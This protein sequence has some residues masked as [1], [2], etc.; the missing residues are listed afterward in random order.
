MIVLEKGKLKT[1]LQSIDDA[2]AEGG[3]VY[4]TCLDFS[5]LTTSIDKKILDCKDHLLQISN[6][7][8][9]LTNLTSSLEGL[10][11]A[12]MDQILRLEKERDNIIRRDT[13]LSNFIDP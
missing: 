6:S 8:N 4:K 13:K 12:V 1:F 7:Y 11:L 10:I 3:K 2:L 5:K 9:L